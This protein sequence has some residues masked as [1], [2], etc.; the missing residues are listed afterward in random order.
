MNDRQNEIVAE[1]LKLISQRG[2][3]E[4][5]IKR[6]ATAIGVTEPAIYRHFASKSDILQAVVDKIE[7]TR[8][9]VVLGATKEQGD[10]SAIF[11]AFF[12]GQARLF[13]REPTLTVILFSEDIFC[14]DGI[15][16][17]RIKTTMDQTIRWIQDH[18]ERGKQSG[19]F[20]KSVDSGTTALML[21]GGFRLLVST[22]RMENFSFPLEDR[23]RA[24]VDSAKELLRDRH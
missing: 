3:Q 17:Q 9:A 7:E 22:W 5:T 1:T 23:T 15:L 6:I 2:I 19:E 4:L 24:F 10:V 14:S 16:F 18:L 12:I 8:N 20:K 13:E 21:I 11:H